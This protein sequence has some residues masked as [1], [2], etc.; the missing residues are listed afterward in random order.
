MNCPQLLIASEIQ[1]AQLPVRKWKS[2]IRVN[3]FLMLES[4]IKEFYGT[5]ILYFSENW[6]IQ[7][8]IKCKK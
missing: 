8:S 2:E 4:Q 1:K 5:T 7:Y 3:I 6:P